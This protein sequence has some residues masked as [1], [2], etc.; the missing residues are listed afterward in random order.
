[1]LQ[2]V[3][4]AWIRVRQNLDQVFKIRFKLSNQLKYGSKQ[5][6]IHH[7]Y[8]TKDPDQ[9]ASLDMDQSYAI[10]N[11]TTQIKIKIRQLTR[12]QIKAR[13]ELAGLVNRGF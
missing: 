11:L 8:S 10:S 5:G 2:I 9:I 13:P 6:K 7:D 12:A 3:A 1:M 4:Q